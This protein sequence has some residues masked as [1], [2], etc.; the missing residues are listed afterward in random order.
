MAERVLIVTADDALAR[1]ACELFAA[2]TGGGVLRER[3][4]AAGLEA[5]ERARPDAVVWDG[6]LPDAE[7]IQA[8]VSEAVTG[9]IS[10]DNHLIVCGALGGFPDDVRI[11]EIE[12]ASEDWGEELTPELKERMPE[13]LEVV[14]SS[15]RP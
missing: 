4:G 10:L 5:C 2:G 12:P 9:V 14:W 6:E 11:I 7:E 1:V 13:I 8:R 3:D 15:T